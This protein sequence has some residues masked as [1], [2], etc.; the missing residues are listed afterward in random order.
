MQTKTELMK[1]FYFFLIFALTG[2]ILQAQPQISFENTTIEF[3]NVKP[4]SNG[5]REFVFRNTGDQTLLIKEVIYNSSHLSVNIT[6]KELQPG[7]SAKI[8]IN[9]DTKVL[10][11]VR[12]T[13]TV[14]SNSQN[15]SITALKIKGNVMDSKKAERKL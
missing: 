10:G 9:Y 5:E 8:V 14:H 2:A 3:D 1:R 12:R 6:N 4:G 13:I 7:S 15:Q 11:P